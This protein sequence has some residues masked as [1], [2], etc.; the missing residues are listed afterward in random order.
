[1][2]KDYYKILE[3]E[4]PVSSR[5]IKTAYRKQCLKWHLDKNPERDTT[6]IIQDIIEA[7][8]FL[9]DEEGRSRYDQTYFKFKK[10]RK[11]KTEKEKATAPNDTKENS[12]EEYYEYEYDFSD[13]ILKKWMYNA[14]Q[15]AKK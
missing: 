11:S 6:K 4:S 13:E 5:E 14:K 10:A 9:K 8:V 1:M 7:Y 15:Q 3:I 12:K 2:F